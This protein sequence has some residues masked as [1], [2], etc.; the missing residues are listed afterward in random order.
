[1]KP[2][3]TLAL[4]RREI[5][6]PAVFEFIVPALAAIR[7]NALGDGVR[8]LGLVGGPLDELHE[9][10]FGEAGFVQQRRAQAQREVV[11]AEVTAAQH[12]ARFVDRTREEHQVGEPCTRIAR[13]APAQADRAHHLNGRRHL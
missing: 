2:H 12:R 8:D 4:V 5:G 13:R 6:D 11:V 3:E 9:R 1:M 7:R 10:C